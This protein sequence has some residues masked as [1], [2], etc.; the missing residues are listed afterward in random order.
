MVGEAGALH[1]CAPLPPGVAPGAPVG[2]PEGACEREPAPASYP[3]APEVP[4]GVVAAV[5]AVSPVDAGSKAV[6]LPDAVAPSFSR[7]TASGSEDGVS[8]VGSE[9]VGKVLVTSTSGYCEVTSIPV[10]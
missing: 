2:A 6:R 4:E 1:V 3:E 10:N 7:K 9:D 8:R 5:G